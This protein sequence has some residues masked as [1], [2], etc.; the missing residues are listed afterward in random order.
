MKRIALLLLLIGC[1]AFAQTGAKSSAKPTVSSV[2]D[3]WIAAFNAKQAD[4]VAALYANDAVMITPDSILNG[5][6]AIRANIQKQL[7]AGATNV[8][9]VSTKSG[10]DADFQWDAGDYSQ[11]VGTKEV[12][13]RYLVNLRMVNGKWV[14]VAHASVPSAATK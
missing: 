6:D 4:K 14:L 7:D 13:G 11:K 9:V 8:Q 2:R 10:G 1:M 3:A 5:R 12:R